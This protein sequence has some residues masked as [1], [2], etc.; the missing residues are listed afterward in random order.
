MAATY[1]V[2]MI[3]N[4]RDALHAVRDSARRVGAFGAAIKGIQESIDEFE[5]EFPDC[6][7]L[8][9]NVSHFVD[10]VYNATKRSKNRSADEAHVHGS[11]I[12]NEYVFFHEGRRISLTMDDVAPNK[13]CRIKRRVYAAFPQEKMRVFPG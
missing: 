4:F 13:L 9:D 7:A 11:I 1:A 8:R 3:Y 6:K 12:G 10:K 2:L 5:A